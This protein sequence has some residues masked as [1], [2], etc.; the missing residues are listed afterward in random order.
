MKKNIYLVAMTMLSL[1]INAQNYTYQWAKT[2]GATNGSSGVG[3]NQVDDEHILDIAV[4]NQNNSYYLTSI[5]D[6]IP[7]LNGQPVTN[8]GGK[9]LLL[10]ST[11]CLGNV[12]WTRT[13][14]SST[15]S[16]LSQKIALDNSGGLYISANIANTATSGSGILPPRFGDNNT[17]PPV[18]ND[19]FQA[20]AGL[21]TGYLLKYSTSNGNLVWRRDFQGDVTAF[22]SNMDVSPP[23]MDSQGNLHL[24]LGFLN[25][26]HLGGLITVPGSFNSTANYQY[27][28]VKYDT[29]GNIV[30]TPALIPITGSTTFSGGYLNFIYDETNSR[31]YLAGSK[32]YPGGSS[33]NFSYN[34]TPISQ[35]AFVL[36]FNSSNFTEIWRREINNGTPNAASDYI[37]GLKKDPVTS[38][39]YISGRFFK[40]SN[41]P[42]LSSF[43][44]YSF[45]TPLTGQISFAMKFNNLGTVVWCTNPVSL[46]DGSSDA[47]I[48]NARMPIALNGN[49]VLLAKGGIQEAWGTYSM[50]RPANDRTDPLIVRFNKETGTVTGIHD[51]LGS[52]GQ[53]DHFTAIAT[54][55]DG[56]IVLGGFIN[57]Q[58]FTSATDN[59]ATIS[60]AAGSSKSDFFFAKLATSATCT[61]LSVE[62]TAAEAGL[63]FYPNPVQDLLNIKS[64][65]KLQSFEVY[66]STGQTIQRGSL[67]NTDAQINM[68]ALTTGIYYVKVKTEKAVVTE[69]VIKK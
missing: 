29:A 67:Q 46:S 56:N 65:T 20:Q 8:Y 48:M 41:N 30:G 19:P 21:R 58:L 52:Y 53:E 28:L 49:E 51:V 40:G 7:L 6:N 17:A 63:Q 60:N 36:A 23:V 54:D 25:G 64:K 15:N 11:D 35:N 42:N 39:I 61:S 4:D 1:L 32:N 33:N 12:R 34:S 43:G 27:Y 69:K 37:F 31:Y 38:D 18:T 26:S 55:V 59:V 68:S 9:D 24:I 3:F 13:I 66:S 44:S 50:S 22:N 14:G 57:Q 45:T 10:F 47:F 2:G 5:Y 16:G 62:E